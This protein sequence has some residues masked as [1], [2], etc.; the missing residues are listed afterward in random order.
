MELNQRW[1][2]SNSRSPPMASV[3]SCRYLQRAVWEQIGGLVNEQALSRGRSQK[4]WWWCGATWPVGLAYDGQS[5]GLCSTWLFQAL[6]PNIS[7]PCCSCAAAGAHRATRP[8][9]CCTHLSGRLRRR[10]SRVEMV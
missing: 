10:S 8:P 9:R 2:T 7:Q 1:K 5:P 6:R 4:C 3:M